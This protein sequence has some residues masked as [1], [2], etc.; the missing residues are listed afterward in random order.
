MSDEFNEFEENSGSDGFSF[1]SI[2]AE[3]KGSAFINGEKRTPPDL[4]QEKADRILRE[5]A[6]MSAASS[7]E[8]PPLNTQGTISTAT[9]RTEISDDPFTDPFLMQEND[10]IP[11]QTD[12]NLYLSEE[13]KTKQEQIQYARQAYQTQQ[14]Y[15]LHR[16]QQ[17]QQPDFEPE[18]SD[19]DDLPMIVTPLEGELEPGKEDARFVTVGSEI[20]VT[21]PEASMYASSDT[22]EF[23][24]M[25]SRM[26]TIAQGQQA[27]QGNMFYDQFSDDSYSEQNQDTIIHRPDEGPLQEQ[28]P[29]FKSRFGFGK[30]DTGNE[31]GDTGLYEDE[32]SEYTVFEDEVFAEPQLRSAVRIFAASCNSVSIRVIPASV[33]TLLMILI[34]YVYEAGMVVPFGIGYSLPHAAGTLILCLLIVMMLCAEI[35]VRGVDFLIKGVP[36]AE[37]LVLFS[38][39][40][41]LISATFTMISGAAMML[42]FCAVSAL[43]LTFATHGEKYNLRAITDTLKTAVGSSEP[44]GVQAEYNVE[45]DKSVLK[46]SFN[47]TDGF[48]NNLMQPDIT[49]IAYRYAAP[50]LL[51]GALL[52]TVLI[53]LVRGGVENSLHILSALLAAAAPFSVLLSFSVPFATV[54]KSTRKSGAAVAGWGGADDICFTDGVCVT[55]DDLFPPG[56]LKLS[57]VKVYD[58]ASPE[59]AIRYTASLILSSGSGLTN[60]FA[61]VLKQQGLSAMKVDDFECHESGIGAVVRGE[62]VSTGSAAFMN[63]L[64][65]RVPDDTNMK[66]AV[67]TAVNNRL[68]AMFAIDY[69][70]LPSIQSALI[71]MLKWRID[72]YFAMR[73]FNV[74]PAMV[75]QKFKVPFESFVFIPAKDSYS[76]SDLYSNKPGRMVAVLVREGLNPYAEAITG[77]RLLKSAAFFA[78]ILSVVSAALGV[79][80]M[81]YMCWTGSFVSASPGNLVV[82]MLCM[83]TTVLIV[84]GYVRLKK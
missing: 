2:L 45:I 64:G 74:T 48:Y 54:T 20:G 36:N 22:G 79:L 53:I 41:S 71:S 66:N 44:Y 56:M 81:F 19:T 40:F 84:C 32:D 46:K 12:Q 9:Q 3:V 23:G 62:Q 15:Q 30:S 43:S 39:L 28:R 18:F 6:E 14:D 47:R 60:L 17:M 1:E 63:L 24:S 52:L 31:Y 35:I 76:L 72:L 34:T 82:F 21:Q 33:I 57:G 78:T 11:G 75:G 65:V 67:Y 51:V 26:G 7:T 42:P 73:D 58:G 77:G 49:E 59:N 55:D 80:I 70:P 83:L 13:E 61:E 29:S 10:N 38:C 68:V 4:L 50:V 5:A 25:N 16:D 69:K 27:D 37:T 8:I